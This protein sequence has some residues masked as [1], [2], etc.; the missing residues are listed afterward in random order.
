MC[1]SIKI[2]K[3]RH[4]WNKKSKQMRVLWNYFDVSG[5]ELYGKV[6]MGLTLFAQC[7]YSSLPSSRRGMSEKKSET[8]FG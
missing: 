5:W 6:Y 2:N 7:R 8:I 3:F 4:V 1:A